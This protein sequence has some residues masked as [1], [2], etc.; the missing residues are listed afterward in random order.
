MKRVRVNLGPNSYDILI[1]Y[2]ILDELGSKMKEFSFSAKALLVT[3]PEVY[4]LYGD[5]VVRSLRNA[6][7]EVKVARVNEGEDYKSLESA[8]Q[9]YDQA[10]QAGLDRK[11]PII[12]LGGGVIGDLAGFVAS[13]Y[14]RGVPFIQV[15][16]TL[17]AQ[18]DSSVGGK[19]AVNHPRGKNII[20]A[21]Y[22]PKLVL[23]DIATLKSLP[24]RE[25]RTG[26]A[27]I[28]KYGVI[29]D[30]EFFYYLEENLQPILIQEPEAMA[31]IVEVSS[32]IKAEIVEQ[33]EK[34]QNIRA[35]LNFGHTLGH[36]VET[37]T[38]YKEYRHGEAVAI[39]MVAAA[40]MAVNLG[41][42]TQGDSFRIATL[43]RNAGL[44]TDFPE[45]KR[46]DIINTIYHD[47]KTVGN[48]LTFILPDSIG[49]VGIVKGVKEEEI[50]Y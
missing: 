20:G 4:N 40:K 36:V 3:N 30:K 18:V 9:L 21:F 15:P 13:T 39:G 24:I 6:G 22:Q 12:A 49:R 8:S 23:S 26:L 42:I 41:L 28:I 25:L 32:R 5:R 34:E 11:S 45:F 43:I 44:P 2:D 37:L 1:G 10:L 29:W 14:M 16:T 47:K 46:L 7:F 17:L 38:E 31:K 27:E 33:D 35:I 19:V 50:I 48:S